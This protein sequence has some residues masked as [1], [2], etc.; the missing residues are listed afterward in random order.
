MAATMR[1]VAGQGEPRLE[2][3][4]DLAERGARRAVIDFWGRLHGFAQLGVPKRRWA[5]VG[6]HHPV[7]RVTETGL[8]CSGR[9]LKSSPP[10]DGDGLGGSIRERSMRPPTHTS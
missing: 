3:G 5:S 8:R 2:A 10:L 7:L 6:R 1:R 4:V 9:R